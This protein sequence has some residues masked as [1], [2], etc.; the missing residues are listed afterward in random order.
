VEDAEKDEF[1]LNLDLD[2]RLGNGDE[3]I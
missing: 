1:K 3:F 2:L